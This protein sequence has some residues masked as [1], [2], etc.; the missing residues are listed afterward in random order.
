[1]LSILLFSYKNTSDDF[2]HTCTHYSLCL[3]ALN[4]G[5]EAAEA[6]KRSKYVPGSCQDGTAVDTGVGEQETS[7]CLPYFV[8][9]HIPVCI[10]SPLK[11]W[12]FYI[13]KLVLE[14]MPP[15]TNDYGKCN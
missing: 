9:K 13:G 8:V 6:Q 11:R 15:S 3:R 1:M 7:N 4:V 12:S 14:F 10:S 2:S 5:W